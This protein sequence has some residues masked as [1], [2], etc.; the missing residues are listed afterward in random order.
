MKFT[1]LDALG[2]RA[3]RAALIFAVMGPGVLVSAHTSMPT[4]SANAAAAQS[5]WTTLF[6]GKDLDGW[7][8][9]GGK[10]KYTVEN[11]EIIGTAVANT[12]NSFLCPPGTY[13]D[14]E[15]ELEF[16]CDPRLNSGVQVRSLA[17]ATKHSPDQPYGYQVEIDMDA[18]RGR[19]WSAGIYDEGR[20]G[21]LY[22]LKGNKEQAAAFT[23]EG[24]EVSKPGEWNTLRIVAIGDS[25]TTFLNGAP[26]ATLKDDVT[27]AGFIGL[28]VHSVSEK[29][30]GTT[31]R[32][33]NVRIKGCPLPEPSC[34]EPSACCASDATS[35]TLTASEV[36][37]G[38]QLL[39]NG[40]DASGWRGS[41]RKDFP[42]KGW[43]IENGTLNVLAK[44]KG[45]DIVTEKT[46]ANFELS[47]DFKM[48]PAANSGIKYFVQPKLANGP[49]FQILDDAKHHDAKKG[50]DGNRTIGSLYDLIPA[51]KD[52]P[53]GTV[54]TWHTAR[55]VA[56]GSQVEHWLDGV[57]VLE[58][59]RHSNAFRARVKAS[60]FKGVTE[61]GEWESGH[62]LLQDHDDAVAF[63][64]I[65]IRELKGGK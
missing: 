43:S 29:N 52:K 21:W 37:E 53:V 31:V 28:Q 23:K 49:E 19:W 54:N 55:V 26:R 7:K 59:D 1:L 47:V 42:P 4:A 2:Q 51:R 64:N 25:I 13:G 36:A 58:Y 18:P 39:W 15:L 30:A 57:K 61:Y 14:F 44:G 20:R 3:I 33:R 48:T 24:G 65:K 22:P 56:R 38:W 34:V 50:R 35:N 32:F 10:A 16:K 8:Q 9:R 45:G 46:Y 12:P 60:K 6:N 40:K 11:G 41:K 63:R 17:K 5:G 62:I 27:K